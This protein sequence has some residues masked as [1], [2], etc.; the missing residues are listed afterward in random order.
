[1]RMPGRKIVFGV[2]YGHIE[3]QT[4]IWYILM[5]RLQQLRMENKLV[6]LM[7]YYN[8]DLFISE[9]YDLTKEFVDLMY[10]NWFLP[11]I[12]RHTRTTNRSATLIDNIIWVNKL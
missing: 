12:S 11:L 8:T 9:T 2:I 7:N 10:C 1:M 5:Q 3:F 4:Q 6:Y